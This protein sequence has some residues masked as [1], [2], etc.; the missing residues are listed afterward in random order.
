MPRIS[1]LQRGLSLRSLRLAISLS[2]LCAGTF[3]PS[4]YGQQSASQQAAA[5]CTISALSL[6]LHGTRD[7]HA[8]L[9][10]LRDA[11]GFER[12]DVMLFQEVVRP[13]QGGGGA[14]DDVARVL[15]MQIAFARGFVLRSGE[16]EGLAVLSRY[17]IV[18]SRVIVL[19]HNDLLWKSRRRVALAVTVET[20]AGQ[21]RVYNL[22]LDTRVNLRA[23]LEQLRPVAEEAAS[24]PGPALVGGDL[25][26]NPYRWVGHTLPVVMAPD[27]GAGVLRYMNTLGYASVFP[28]KTPTSRW[29]RMQLDW[30][31]L[32]NLEVGPVAVQP[33][34]FSD[35]HA[36][37]ACLQLASA[38]QRT[39]PLSN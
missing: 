20:P 27:Q 9:T 6:N 31:F 11:G 35:H 15:G 12:A 30:L 14:V 25:N 39:L 32:R 26:T 5:K 1:Q 10:A 36:L 38:A 29:F 19:Q 37:C 22:H 4:A 16:E 24:A 34:S 28:R 33:I 3:S 8:I 18:Q 7:G 17:P 2:L 13:R 23:R 21:L